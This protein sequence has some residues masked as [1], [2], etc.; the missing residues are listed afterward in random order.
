M[1]D[2]LSPLTTFK[3]WRFGDIVVTC[4]LEMAPLTL[5]PETQLKTT[6]D[7]VLAEP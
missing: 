3:M 4:V 7:V 1:T 5:S 6:K 2:A